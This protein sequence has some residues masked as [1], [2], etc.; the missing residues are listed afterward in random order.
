MCEENRLIY[1]TIKM[2]VDVADKRQSH[3][4]EH[5]SHVTLF[6]LSSTLCHPID[7]FTPVS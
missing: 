2:Q 3:R 6:L 5:R 1:R 7:Y 4:L